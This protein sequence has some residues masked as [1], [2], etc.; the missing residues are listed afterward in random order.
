MKLQNETLA[1]I[2]NVGHP[3]RRAIK[4]ALREL[5]PY[6]WVVYCANMPMRFA[7]GQVPRLR[8]PLSAAPARD[9]LRLRDAGAAA[10]NPSFPGPGVAKATL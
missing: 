5:A 6:R 9:D 3:L 8:A 2:D 1:V 7:R 4:L 10:V